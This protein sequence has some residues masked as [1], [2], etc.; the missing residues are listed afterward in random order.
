MRDEK[1]RKT[2]EY[3]R[4]INF[5]KF[6][7]ISLEKLVASLPASALSIFD[8]MFDSDLSPDAI[9]SIKE[10]GIYPICT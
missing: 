5:F 2:Y 10:K 1:I 8:S 9:N 7:T 3:L 6:L 4:F